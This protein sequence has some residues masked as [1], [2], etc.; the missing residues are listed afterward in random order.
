MAIRQGRCT[1][2]GNCP[3][4]DSRKVVNVPEGVDFVCT[5]CKGQLTEV[6]APNAFPTKIVMIAWCYSRYWACPLGGSLDESPR[7]GEQVLAE[8]SPA[9]Q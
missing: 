2:F 7:V 3:V 1:N 8:L 4:A 9:D 6:A 5:D